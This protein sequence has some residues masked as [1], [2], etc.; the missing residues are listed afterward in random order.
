MHAARKFILQFF[1]ISEIVNFA[2]YIFAKPVFE[3]CAGIHIKCKSTKLFY[4]FIEAI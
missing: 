1:R 2:K 4:N 3:H